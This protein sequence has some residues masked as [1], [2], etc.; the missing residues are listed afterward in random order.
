MLGL[1]EER[2]LINILEI[3]DCVL[4]MVVKDDYVLVLRIYYLR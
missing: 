3:E 2:I 4:V 1:L